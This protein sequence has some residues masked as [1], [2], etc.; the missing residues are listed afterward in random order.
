MI[1]IAG[2]CH[3]DNRVYQQICLGFFSGTKRKFLMGAVQWVA[4]LKS[5]NF[6]PAK[7][8][9]IGAQ[10]VRRVAPAQ[11]IIMHRLLN[12]DHRATQINCSGL[13]MQIIHGRMGA[14]IGAKNL[15]GLMGFVWG[16]VVSDSHRGKD[17][18]LLIAQGDVL[19]KG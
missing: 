10:F 12:A 16:P 6:A 5:D 7:L 15:L 4:G 9:K 1:D 19:A 2:F 11:K 13:L 18:T 3:A 17:D 14:V 8:A